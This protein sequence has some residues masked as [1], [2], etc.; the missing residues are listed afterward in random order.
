MKP[1]HTPGPWH[2]D[3]F[4]VVHNTTEGYSMKLITI[5]NKRKNPQEYAAN[6]K[7]MA[8]APDLLEICQEIAN[9]SNVDLC[10][11]ERRI[12]LYHAIQKACG[13]LRGGKEHTK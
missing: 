3:C 1:K 8:A 7:L 10:H 2:D 12:R 6:L 5:E 11:S 13:E 4:D 9:D